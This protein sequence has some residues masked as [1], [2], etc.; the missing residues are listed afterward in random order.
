MKSDIFLTHRWPS[1]YMG[2][3][4]ILF[5]NRFLPQAGLLLKREEELFP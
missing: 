5:L 2:E 3:K 4:F 1:A